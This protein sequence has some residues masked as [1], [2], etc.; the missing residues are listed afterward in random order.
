MTGMT[1]DHTGIDELRE[2]AIA[3]LRSAGTIASKEVEAAFR[4]VP[5][6]VFIPEADL[7]TAWD[8]YRAVVTKRDEHGNALSSVSD[9]H[10]QSYMLTE[11]RIEPGMNVLEIGSGGYNAALIAELVGPDG[12]VT[13]VDIDPWVTD[14]AGRLL[15]AAGYSSRVEVVLADAEAGVPD[16]APYDRILVT[17]GSWDIPPAWIEQLTDDGLLVVPLRMRGLTRTIAFAKDPATGGLQ[18]VGAK[19]FGFVPMQGSGSHQAKLVVLRDGEVT[20]RFDD[21]DH[22]TVLEPGLLDGVFDTERVEVWSG[23]VIGNFELLDTVQMWMATTQPGFCWLT[24]DRD[25]DSGVVSLP[26]TRTMAMAVVDG[27]DLAYILTRPSAQ[28]DKS[29]EFGVHAYGPRARELAERVAEQLRVWGRDHRG[30]P[31]PCYRIYPAGTADALI[32]DGRVIDKRHVR[33]LISWPQTAA[34]D[35]GQDASS[36]ST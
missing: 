21:D 2:A 12:R 13:T 26:G 20:L 11:A 6:H 1:T 22:T 14:R 25:K 35:A 32:P 31:G 19:L 34:T 36:R 10:V 8:P 27:P 9:M 16:G 18:S 7:A 17:V 28:A 3:E 5:R 30:G 29:S 4:A 23:A 33:V 24:L 15:D